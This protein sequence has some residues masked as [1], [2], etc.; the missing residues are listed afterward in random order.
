MLVEGPP[1]TFL[2]ELGP[3]SGG[4]Q[5]H[6]ASS[7]DHPFRESSNTGQEE[8]RELLGLTD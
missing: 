4:E 2:P 3:D 6:L 8:K 1:Q 5:G 7:I